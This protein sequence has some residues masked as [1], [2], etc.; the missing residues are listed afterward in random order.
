MKPEEQIQNFLTYN[1]ESLDEIEK[2]QPEIFE[3]FSTV[4]KNV[5]TK[6]T[7]GE[8]TKG[9]SNTSNSIFE[10]MIPYRNKTSYVEYL[11]ANPRT[12]LR[13][14]YGFNQELA[15]KYNEEMSNVE[16]LIEMQFKG[17][18]VMF[19]VRSTI[20]G[21]LYELSGYETSVK[22]GKTIITL[23]IKEKE[24]AINDIKLVFSEKTWVDF[25]CFGLAS[26]E[27]Q[28]YP[29]NKRFHS[30]VDRITYIAEY[31][32][33]EKIVEIYAP[34]SL[35]IGREIQLSKYEDNV[36]VSCTGII[37]SCYVE[38]EN[39][40]VKPGLRIAIKITDI[41]TTK[42]TPAIKLKTQIGD[43]PIEDHV[44]SRTLVENDVVYASLIIGNE[45][46]ILNSLNFLAD[47]EYNSVKVIYLGFANDRNETLRPVFDEVTP[48]N[49][50]KA[51]IQ[52][53]KLKIIANTGTNV[54]PEG[55]KIA[56]NTGNRQSPTQSAAAVEPGT[57]A[58]GNDND[59]Y[60]VSQN[61]KG[62]NQWRRMKIAPTSEI[63]PITEYNLFEITNLID[64]TK[65]L[66]SFLD[67]KDNEYKT[68][69]DLIEQLENQKKVLE[70]KT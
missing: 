17:L 40:K 68:T 69:K 5:F 54:Y 55:T 70:S 64:E 24:F 67:I 32:N 38:T 45:T 53:N 26:E 61:K 6:Y 25:L 12:G 33:L 60:R 11:D 56:K 66:L 35:F 23:I 13:N 27:Y 31:P 46:H 48:S 28:I 63:I 62:V 2:N 7:G 43:K 49:P 37:M 4:I 21:K 15:E 58:I 52:P 3:A 20:S 22:M 30:I 16:K 1:Q 8:P 34:L 51:H 44:E 50:G 14:N 39:N 47:P 65:E 9:S 36:K 10:Q 29:Q 42:G 59:W 57:M 41:N 18:F 19:D